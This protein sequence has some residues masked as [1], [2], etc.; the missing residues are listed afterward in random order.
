MP[1]LLSASGVLPNEAISQKK[2]MEL[3]ES[4]NASN[5]R[6]KKILKAVYEKVAVQERY[7]VFDPALCRRSVSPVLPEL[8]LIM[9]RAILV[10]MNT[11]AIP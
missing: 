7:S 11:A 3:A 4:H 9:V 5:A 1:F 10:T 8:P 2:T 6:Q